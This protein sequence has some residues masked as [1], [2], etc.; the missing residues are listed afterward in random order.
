MESVVSIGMGGDNTLLDAMTPRT[1][2][3]AYPYQGNSEQGFRIRKF[4][5][6][7]LLHELGGQ[8]MVAERLKE[9]IELA[10]S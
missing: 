6:K 2:A 7:G 4:A 8:D 10:L 3:L 5:E 1:P 9:R